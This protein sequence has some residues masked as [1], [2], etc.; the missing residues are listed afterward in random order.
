MAWYKKVFSHHTEDQKEFA[1]VS[2]DELNPVA[3]TTANGDNAHVSVMHDLVYQE[4]HSE[5]LSVLVQKA[6]E[7]IPAL[8]VSGKSTDDGVETNLLSVHI[9][10]TLLKVLGQIAGSGAGVDELLP[11]STLIDALVELAIST[12]ANPKFGT[13]QQAERKVSALRREIHAA[14]IELG[15]E[16][17]SELASAFAAIRD[18]SQEYGTECDEELGV[19]EMN[20]ADADEYRPSKVSWGPVQGEEPDPIAN[21]QVEDE[22]DDIE[23]G[24]GEDDDGDEESLDDEDN[25]EDEEDEDDE[26]DAEATRAEFVEELMLMGFPEDWCVLALKQ[27]ENDIVGASAWI[28]DNL[29]YLSKLQSSLDKERDKNRDSPRFDEEDDDFDTLTEN[30]TSGSSQPPSL[31]AS[32]SWVQSASWRGT[33]SMANVE[34]HAGMSLDIKDFTSDDHK[35]PPL[36]DKEMGRKLFAE[37]YFPFED[38]G[39]LSNTKSRFMRTWRTEAMEMK[40]K[41]VPSTTEPIS[42]NE[43]DASPFEEEFQT[44]ISQLDLQALLKLLRTFE[45][46]LA[47]LYARQAM[48]ALMHHVSACVTGVE[49]ALLT[50]LMIPYEQ[51]FN[52]MKLAMLRGDQFTIISSSRPTTGGRWKLHEYSTAD[53]FTRALKYFVRKDPSVFT[54]AAFDFCLGELEAAAANKT[55]EAILWT[56]RALQRTDK[57]VIDEP[58]VE[59]SWGFIGD[60]ALYYQRNRIRAYGET[61]TEGDCIGLRLDCEKGELS[62]SKNGVDLGMAFDNIVGEVCPAVAFYSRHQKI[63]FARDSY[64]NCSGAEIF[65]TGEDGQASVE[66]CLIVCE[67]MSNWVA[68]KPMRVLTSAA[69]FKMTSAWLAGSTKFVTTRSGKSLWVDVTKEGCGRLGFASD[70]RVRTPRGNGV[71]V[72]VAAGRIWVEVDN[73]PGAW[74]FHPSKLRLVTMTSSTTTN[75]LTPR[76]GSDQ[77]GLRTARNGAEDTKVIELDG[78]N[79]PISA[80]DVAT[81]SLTLSQQE[82]TQY[83]GHA[84]WNI[85]VDRELLGVVNDLCEVS[86]LSPWN[87][88][89][90]QLLKLIEEKATLL[91]VTSMASIFALAQ[92]KRE[93]MVVA[94]FAILR[95]GNFLFVCVKNALFTSLMEKTANSP[96]KSDDEYDYPEDLPQLQVN[97]L[98]AAAA[99]CHQGTINSL[100]LSLFG[101]AFEELHF[102]PLKTLRMVY[103]H[104]MDDG[105]LRSFKVKFEGEGVDDYGGPYREFFSQ[106]FAELQ[107]LH[108]PESAS[109]SNNAAISS[110]EG[111]NVSLK[112]ESGVPVSS[113]MLPFFLPSPNWRNGVGANRE[114]FVLNGALITRQFNDSGSENIKQGANDG[115]VHSEDRSLCESAEERRQLF[116]EMLYFLGQMFGT[117]LRTRVCVRLDL[118][119]S[120]W[121]QLVAEDDSNPE[122]A[123][124]TLREIDFVAYSLWKTL[125]GILDDFRRLQSAAN[126]HPDVASVRHRELEEQLAAMDLDFTTILSDGRTVELC[127]D[128]TNTAVTLANLEKYLG[129]MLRARVEETQEVMNI[130]KQGLHS[131]MP[132]SA[133]A[134]LTWSELEKRM[135]GVAEVDV[136]LLQANTEYD[137]GLSANDE[138]I[139]RFWRVLESFESEDKRAFLRFVWARSRLP[140]GSAQFHQ[141][142]KIQALASS[143]TDNTSAGATTTGGWMDSQMPKSHTCFFALQLP[144]YSTDDICRDRVLYAVRNCVEMDGDFRLADNEMT[145]WTG[146][147]PTD[148]LRI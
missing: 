90:T 63:S 146:I 83:G 32:N 88:T 28:V 39:Y 56:Q 82:L 14:M 110:I 68:N 54:T 3:A 61:F 23:G 84:L 79:N 8:Y 135:C 99:K 50:Q 129:A 148:Q 124:E 70:D 101:Q 128:G 103:S 47:I 59:L 76:L 96:K 116:C 42:E 136:K 48:V 145:G 104:P 94:R 139:Q 126:S 71:V 117:C 27:T 121:K 18:N 86:R 137:D 29:E 40:T 147:N 133:L 92:E 12:D 38:G 75:S 132:V 58:G 52:L 43:R 105:Q 31:N 5:L 21:A 60:K 102:L 6:E 77:T 114:K 1:V 72:G 36:N 7:L 11:K 26:A 64:V 143:G 108:E 69:V 20:V 34:E 80:S 57:T 127:A 89:P 37:M 109:G 65:T 140:Q 4:R 22:G 98:K 74:Y 111:G 85:A 46:S 81:P 106:F 73:E 33:E 67:M 66:D 120:V 125:Q 9:G 10:C 62:F 19:D 25:G 78:G 112:Q 107:M 113:C 15:E 45:N 13:L 2:T 95:Y 119:M 115:Q 51:V 100:F 144:R 49:N 97:R 118:A 141:K 91:E 17:E 87:L 130:I 44:K 142:F 53:V 35:I 30:P 134:L 123:L 131:I 41:A 24:E 138:F 55:Y 16:G 122:S 93:K